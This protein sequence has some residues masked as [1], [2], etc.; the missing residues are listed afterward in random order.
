MPETTAELSNQNDLFRNL[1]IGTRPTTNNSSSHVTD[2]DSVQSEI[3]EKEIEE[4][5]ESIPFQEILGQQIINLTA[6]DAVNPQ[7]PNHPAIESS[8]TK[9][10]HEDINGRDSSILY[11]TLVNGSTQRNANNPNILSSLEGRI[12]GFSSL[13]E[14][15]EKGF[16]LNP[17]EKQILDV[18]NSTNILSRTFIKHPETVVQNSTQNPSLENGVVNNHS[19]VNIHD[20]FALDINHQNL[21]PSSF[22]ERK[23][24][25]TDIRNNVTFHP[26]LNPPLSMGREFDNLSGHD[27][28]AS[29]GSGIGE[30][31]VELLRNLVGLQKLDQSIPVTIQEPAFAVSDNMITARE[32]P[33]AFKS[34]AQD[35]SQKKRPYTPIPEIN[36]QTLITEKHIEN[37]LSK[38][39]SKAPSVHDIPGTSQT[40]GER[41]LFDNFAQ[42]ESASNPTPFGTYIQKT[43]SR[44]PS[45]TDTQIMTDDIPS[46]TTNFTQNT[47]VF[48]GSDTTQL[49]SIEAPKESLSS[50]HNK[51]FTAG[52]E[53]AYNIMNQL[54]QK[55][56]LIHHGDK[57]EIKLHLTP[58]E[59]GSV[60]IHFTEENDEIEA[61]I[62]V[63]NAEV[64]AIIENNAHRLK[65]SV[66]ANGVEIH[67]LEVYI[68]TNNEYKQKFSENRDSNNQHFQTKSQEDRNG[69][70]SGNER[71]VNNNLQ[72]EVSINT[73]NLIVDYII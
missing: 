33:T 7:K 19:N 37:N 35:I 10:F 53:H 3:G 27:L 45:P 13:T 52:I 71:N 36:N 8:A 26:H 48:R 54:F 34:L 59:L 47:E 65:E 61:K 17:S 42:K 6:Q 12:D 23:L 5:I 15:D 30:R 51:S 49:L 29:V 20:P 18:I 41:G 68:Q 62:F 28:P 55:I 25:E 67:K 72:T 58:P 70:L 69:N 4:S 32:L 2:T 31:D 43:H 57:S 38:I 39:T 40:N 21:S 56:S 66:A 64:K 22:P 14:K 11:K 60:K 46:T 63:E 50:T 16:D 1:F 44:Y 24:R 9:L 73:S